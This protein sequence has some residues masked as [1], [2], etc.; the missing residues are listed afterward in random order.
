MVLRALIALI[1]LAF[2]ASAL[3]TSADQQFEDFKRRFA[4]VYTTPAAE[5]KAHS[6]KHYFLRQ[7]FNPFFPKKTKYTFP[8]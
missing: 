2:Y 5:A 7:S 8:V 1:M 3:A 6:P 4:K